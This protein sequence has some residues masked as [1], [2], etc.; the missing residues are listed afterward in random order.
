MSHADDM[1]WLG[2]HLV[3]GAII[4]VV[5]LVVATVCLWGWYEYHGPYTPGSDPRIALSMII[6]M[7]GL[8]LSPVVGAVL[9][10]AAVLTWKTVKS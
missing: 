2:K 3:L 9:W 7:M 6:P 4:G 1:A 10:L 5:I 8:P